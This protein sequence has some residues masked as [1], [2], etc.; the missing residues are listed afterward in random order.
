MSGEVTLGSSRNTISPLLRIQ[1]S[2]GQYEINIQGWIK[3]RNDGLIKTLPHQ[4]MYNP[5]AMRVYETLLILL[6]HCGFDF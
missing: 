1:G 2:M 4:H 3:G 6:I 5:Q